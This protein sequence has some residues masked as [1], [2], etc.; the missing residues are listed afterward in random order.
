MYAHI[1]QVHLFDYSSLLSSRILPI[2]PHLTLFS[3]LSYLLTY[4]H[5]LFPPSSTLCLPPY[6]PSP[7]ALFPSPHGAPHSLALSF[8]LT[9]LL[10]FSL[11]LPPSPPLSLLS[12]LFL[13]SLSSPPTSLSSPSALLCLL[14]SPLGHWCDMHLSLQNGDTPLMVATRMGHDGCVQLLLNKGALVDLLSNV[15]AFWISPGSHL[16]PPPSNL[17]GHSTPN[18][19]GFRQHGSQ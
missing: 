13:P 6:F 9:H 10:L 2:Q 7:S 8:P 1:T 4:L 5:H 12:P 19:R 16:P 15:S 3:F 18:Q 11:L 17:L 14:P